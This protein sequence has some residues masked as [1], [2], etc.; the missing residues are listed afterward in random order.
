M[1]R[2][3]G[4]STLPTLFPGR[5]LLPSTIVSTA[6]NYAIHAVCFLT[7]REKMIQKQHEEVNDEEGDGQKQHVILEKDLTTGLS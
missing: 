3:I 1:S 7:G 5:V 6:D 4:I 2:I